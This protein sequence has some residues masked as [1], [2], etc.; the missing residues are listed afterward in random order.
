[1]KQKVL[2]TIWVLIGCIT[3]IC[4]CGKVEKQD[5]SCSEDDY[6]WD[7]NIIVSLSEEGMKKKNLES[8]NDVKGFPILLLP[9]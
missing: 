5:V 2:I 8:R 6:I 7:N 9:I 4:A 3:M 1:M